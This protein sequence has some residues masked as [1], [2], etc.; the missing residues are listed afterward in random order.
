MYSGRR[1]K[2]MFVQRCMGSP[3]HM[4]CVTPPP[5][6]ASKVP[7][8]CHTHEPGSSGVCV[9]T[10][11]V[12]SASEV[13]CVFCGG[14]WMNIMCAMSLCP[15]PFQHPVSYLHFRRVL[16]FRV[17]GVQ[18][19]STA[20]RPGDRVV[21]GIYAPRAWKRLSEREACLQLSFTGTGKLVAILVINTTWHLEPRWPL[22]E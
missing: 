17:W 15:S 16:K 20:R 19:Q 21:H 22:V 7:K 13:V 5:A 12:D 11:T 14:L 10:K 18:A 2:Y 3:T 1:A 9:T 4:S 6:L 8:Q